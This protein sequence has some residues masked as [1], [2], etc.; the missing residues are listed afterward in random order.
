[1]GSFL[2]SNRQLVIAD[3]GQDGLEKN[4]GGTLIGLSKLQNWGLWRLHSHLAIWQWQDLIISS[5]SRCSRSSSVPP[6]SQKGPSEEEPVQYLLL[7]NIGLTRCPEED[8][9]LPSRQTRGYPE[10]LLAFWEVLFLPSVQQYSCRYGRQAC[11]R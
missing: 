6:S 7:P 8:L 11:Y 9:Y 2:P 10:E 5:I 1:M 3:G 4:R